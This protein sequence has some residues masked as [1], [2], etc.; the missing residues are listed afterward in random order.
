MQLLY[1]QPAFAHAARAGTYNFRALSVDSTAGDRR[2]G[3]SRCARIGVE[4]V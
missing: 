3:L 1:P 4:H 2:R